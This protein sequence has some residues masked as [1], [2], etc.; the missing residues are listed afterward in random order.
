MKDLRKPKKT[1]VKEDSV[2]QEIRKERR[3]NTNLN[4]YR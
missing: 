2:P 1:Q 4:F 3:P